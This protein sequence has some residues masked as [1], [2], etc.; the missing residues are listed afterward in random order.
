MILNADVVIGIS[1]TNL[2]LVKKT[3][4]NSETDVI[5]AITAYSVVR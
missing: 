3:C 2:S 4:N 5:L 1:Y